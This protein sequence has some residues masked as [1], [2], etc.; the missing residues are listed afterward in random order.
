MDILFH[1]VLMNVQLKY[2]SVL[3][4]TLDVKVEYS[5]FRLLR[6]GSTSEAQNVEIPKAVIEANNRWRKQARSKGMKPSMSMMNHYSDARVSVPAL[7]RYS[8]LL[9]G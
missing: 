6:Q 1:T 8:K 4:E 9:P 5:T 2:S 7:T 3:L